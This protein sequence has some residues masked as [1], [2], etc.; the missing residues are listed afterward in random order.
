LTN[1]YFYK[2]LKKNFSCGDRCRRNLIYYTTSTTRADFK[3]W[4]ELVQMYWNGV[5]KENLMRLK[6]VKNLQDFLQRDLISKLK[7]SIEFA[8]R[9]HSD[10]LR[11][12]V[13]EQAK[14]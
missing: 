10:A 2:N 13:S 12:L 1:I 9:E 4:Q 5:K 11:D 8:F 7:E 3:N 6:D 14:N